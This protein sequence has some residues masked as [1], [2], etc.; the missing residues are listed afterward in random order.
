MTLFEIKGHTWVHK[1]S[2]N[3]LRIIN[4][5]AGKCQLALSYR[6]VCPVE[7]DGE[8]R[9]GDLRVIS[10]LWTWCPSQVG[11]LINHLLQSELKVTNPSTSE[12]LH[13]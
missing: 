13:T 7:R 4:R 3:L 11:V 1:Y 6:G 10:G 8:I 2:A 12:L 9:A 5:I